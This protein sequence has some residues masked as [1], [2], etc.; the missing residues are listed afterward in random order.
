MRPH[1][2]RRHALRVAGL[3]CCLSLCLAPPGRAEDAAAPPAADAAA[4]QIGRSIF[5]ANEVNGQLG[6]AAPKRLVVDDDIVFAEDISTGDAAKAVIEFRDGSTF[7]IGPDA[8]I[9][10][11]SFVFNPEESTSHKAVQVARGVFR[12]VSGFAASD[13]ETRI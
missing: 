2:A 7:E 12:Y 9:R 11:D 6:E 3:C 10:I 13:Q 4:S 8:S 5:I 1:L